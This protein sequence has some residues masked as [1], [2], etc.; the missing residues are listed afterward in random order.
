[1]TRWRDGRHGRPKGSYQ[2]Q[3]RDMKRKELKRRRTE[4]PIDEVLE[5][6]RARRDARVTAMH[7]E[8]AHRSCGK[9]Y[10]Y[11]DESEALSMAAR[12]VLDGAPMLRAYKCRYCG[13][14]HL[15]KQPEA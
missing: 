7:G 2:R 13:G 10:R 8:Q 11:A 3:I 15:T 9:K 1:M 4:T 12:C 5:R 14:W 6:E